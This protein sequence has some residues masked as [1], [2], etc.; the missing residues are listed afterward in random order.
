MAQVGPLRECRGQGVVQTGVSSP[1]PFTVLVVTTI[2]L[3]SS[4]AAFCLKHIAPVALLVV[5]LVSQTDRLVDRLG[6][7]HAVAVLGICFFE[8][9]VKSAFVQFL[10]I[11]NH[12]RKNFTLSS[13]F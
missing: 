2:L 6:L 1:A 9:P 3:T 8:G 7:E 13:V 11:L 12:H 5:K 10:W 4:R